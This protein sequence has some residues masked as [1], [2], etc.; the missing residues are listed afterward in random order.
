MRLHLLRHGE[1]ASNAARVYAGRSE[2]PLTA[3]GR[4]QALEAGRRLLGEGV[5][6]IHSSPLRRAVETAGVLASALQVPVRVEEDL[7]EMALGPWEGLSEE[8]VARR[9]PREWAV[10][11]TSPTRLQLPGRETLAEVLRRVVPCLERI[12][13]A[14]P[15]GAVAVVSHHAPIRVAML[16]HAGMELTHY[17]AASVGNCVPVEVEMGLPTARAIIDG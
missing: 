8:E 15:D 16:H 9:Y 3:R 7:T 12:S 11:Q 4:A 6:A 1:T 10:W 5:S 2:E 13:R 14:H 17:R